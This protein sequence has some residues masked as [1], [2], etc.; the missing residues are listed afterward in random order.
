MTLCRPDTPDIKQSGRC[1]FYRCCPGDWLTRM[2][3]HKQFLNPQQ[4]PQDIYQQVNIN[5]TFVTCVII[6]HCKQ[7]RNTMPSLTR[8]KHSCSALRPGMVLHCKYHKHLARVD[9]PLAVKENTHADTQASRQTAV[10]EP[11]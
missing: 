7:Y 11:T 9:M 4:G 8:G 10:A 2:V 1:L 5:S 3:F 6:A